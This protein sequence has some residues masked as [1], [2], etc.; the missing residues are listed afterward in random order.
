ME[1]AARHEP[2][3]AGVP[4]DGRRTG[5]R[6]AAVIV[7]SSF[8]SAPDLAASKFPFFP[9]RWFCKFRYDS[10][11]K[12]ASLRCPVLVIHSPDDDLIPFENGQKLFDA[13]SEPKQFLTIEGGHNEGFM[14]S[15][16]A[17]FRGMG[18]FLDKHIP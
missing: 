4:A 6:P 9:V 1:L 3:P 2:A 8:T 15:G 13:A 5:R 17:Y 7:E 10:L 14:V 12:I 18:E 16:D 11:G